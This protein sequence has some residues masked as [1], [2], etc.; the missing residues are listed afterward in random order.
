MSGCC[1]YMCLEND[2][3]SV[4]NLVAI[5][6]AAPLLPVHLAFMG[7]TNPFHR[8]TWWCVC[9]FI[10]SCSTYVRLYV[11]E[12]VNPIS[13]LVSRVESRQIHLIRCHISN[14]TQILEFYTHEGLLEIGPA[15][16]IR[17]ALLVLTLFHFRDVIL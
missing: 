13:L 14:S 15:H 9:L 6:V 17:P 11:L 4:K 16:K 1:S 7:P 8:H 3:S 2:F 12:Y 10:A 5:H